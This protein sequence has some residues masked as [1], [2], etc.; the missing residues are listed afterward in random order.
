M[1]IYMRDLEIRIFFDSTELELKTGKDLRWDITAYPC[2]PDKPVTEEELQMALNF[3][4]AAE[5][6]L[7]NK[8]TLLKKE[9]FEISKRLNKEI[10]DLTEESK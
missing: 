5:K 2:G 6:D 8:I 7:Q 10:D 1:E 9:S 4:K 3:M